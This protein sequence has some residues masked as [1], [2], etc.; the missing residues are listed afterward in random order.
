M[1]SLVDLDILVNVGATKKALHYKRLIGGNK[2]SL[3]DGISWCYQGRYMSGINGCKYISQIL[4][5]E[6]RKTKKS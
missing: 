6:H 2:S 1:N 3:K 4:C 5:F